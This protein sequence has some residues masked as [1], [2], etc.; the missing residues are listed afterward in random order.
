MCLFCRQNKRF[1]QTQAQVDE[2][3]IIIIIVWYHIDLSFD[4]MY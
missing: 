4:Y 1:Q 2:V 3:I